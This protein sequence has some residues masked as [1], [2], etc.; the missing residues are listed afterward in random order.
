MSAFSSSKSADANAFEASV[1]HT[2][3][4]PRN[5]NDPIGLLGSFKPALALRIAFETR[6]NASSCP[7][8]LFFRIFSRSASFSISL[9]TSLDAG[10][11]VHLAIIV[12]ISSASTTSLCISFS[13]S[14]FSN[15][16][17]SFCFSG[18]VL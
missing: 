12:A 3:V 9:A 13:D 6:C 14:L 4:G 1:F 17:N 11:Q 10:I 15:S 7:T 18:R 16:A 5:R 2:H 8:T